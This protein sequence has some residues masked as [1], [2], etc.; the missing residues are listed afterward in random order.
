MKMHLVKSAIIAA[1]VSA[2]IPPSIACAEPNDKQP[3]QSWYI[4]EWAA[5]AF[6]RLNSLDP[7]DPAGQLAKRVGFFA[8]RDAFE[9]YMV[10]ARKGT[11]F[12]IV[13]AGGMALYDTVTAPIVRKL[14]QGKWQVETVV[15]EKTLEGENDSLGCISVTQVLSE[16]PP[17]PGV[18]EVGIETVVT[19]PSKIKCP[20][21]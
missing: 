16:L 14:E 7:G 6:V 10:Q 4:G 5:T 8:S 11:A 13:S 1:A 17:A 9:R 15:R 18:N 3:D 2:C 12:R 21:D 19:K 20:Q